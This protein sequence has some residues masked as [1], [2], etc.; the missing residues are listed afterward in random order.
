MASMVW[1]RDELSLILR[2]R[3]AM[4]PPHARP[5]LL[6]PFIGDGTD[7]RVFVIGGEASPA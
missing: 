5:A 4:D 1:S 3:S 6:Q 7:Y 2:H